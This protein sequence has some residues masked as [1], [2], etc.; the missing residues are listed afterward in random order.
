MKDRKA[1]LKE[2]KTG[3]DPIKQDLNAVTDFLT[4][5][6]K[7]EN[8]LLIVIDAFWCEGVERKYLLFDPKRKR[9]Q[10]FKTY[11]A[12]KSQYLKLKPQKAI[13][14]EAGFWGLSK[15]SLNTEFK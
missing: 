5:L 4:E 6:C 8:A 7:S 11:D 12:L 14:A 2:I 9:A 13:L 10:H 3:V 15:I 1:L